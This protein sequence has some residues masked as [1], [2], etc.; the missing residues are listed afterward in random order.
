MIRD[1]VRS[2]KE[3]STLIPSHPTLYRHAYIGVF[4]PSIIYIPFTTTVADGPVQRRI[5]HTPFRGSQTPPCISHTTIYDRYKQER[6]WKLGSGNF[7]NRLSRRNGA[8]PSI[9]VSYKKVL[10][11]SAELTISKSSSVL[12]GLGGRWAVRSTGWSCGTV[13]RLTGRLGRLMGCAK[14]LVGYE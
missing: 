8:V 3:T 11:S 1:L 10:C 2:G 12:T 14:G 9:E 5:S 7:S 6:Q 4:R 13:G